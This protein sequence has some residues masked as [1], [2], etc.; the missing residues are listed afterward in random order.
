MIDY[1][2]QSKKKLDGVGAYN[3]PFF[4]N[5]SSHK[6]AKITCWFSENIS[7]ASSQVEKWLGG[8]PMVHA[9]TLVVAH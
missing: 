9:F 3:I 6:Y 2:L 5:I 1:I 8:M 4:G 7:C